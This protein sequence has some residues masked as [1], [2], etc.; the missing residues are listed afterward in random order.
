MALIIGIG[1]LSLGSMTILGILRNP[2]CKLVLTNDGIEMPGMRGGKMTLYQ[3]TKME[4]FKFA[5]VG[6]LQV[7]EIMLDNGS[8]VNISKQNLKNG[9]DYESL[10][11]DILLRLGGNG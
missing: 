2:E 4:S 10:K 5:V 11:S 9:E 8:R 1:L 6:E 7:I 3:Y